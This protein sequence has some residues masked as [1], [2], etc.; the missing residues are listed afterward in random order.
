MAMAAMKARDKTALPLRSSEIYDERATT[1]LEYPAY[2]AGTLFAKLARQMMKHQ[3]TQH[4][5]E[6]RFGKRK[7]FNNII[8]KY[9]IE[10]AFRAFSPALAIISV[11]GSIP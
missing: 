1:R 10:P 8:F 2:L 4:G 3:R 11:E 9:D 5:I 7:R 6:L